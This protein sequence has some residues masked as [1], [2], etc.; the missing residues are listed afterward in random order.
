MAAKTDP[1]AGA[2]IALAGMAVSCARTA[3]V[4]RLIKRDAK[5]MR[6]RVRRGVVPSFN[7][8][9]TPVLTDDGKMVALPSVYVNTDGTQALTPDHKRALVFAYIADDATAYA[10]MQGE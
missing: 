5:A 2:R 3:D 8:D 4:A 6:D 9:G 10:L 7:D 1:T